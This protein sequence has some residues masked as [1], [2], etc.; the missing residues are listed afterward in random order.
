MPDSRPRPPLPAWDGTVTANA[1]SAPRAS[2]ASGKTPSAAASARHK[3]GVFAALAARS[4]PR[5]TTRPPVAALFG[6]VADLAG[7]GAGALSLER[8]RHAPNSAERRALN[9]AAE[10]AR[11]QDLAHGDV[12]GSPRRL[13]DVR[14][15]VADAELF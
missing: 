14:R 5:A 4:A 11:A 7:D 3:A 15:A 6:E 9:R 8:A 2:G 12:E 10:H 1:A 13:R